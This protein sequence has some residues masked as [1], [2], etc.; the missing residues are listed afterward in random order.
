MEE[1]IIVKTNKSKNGYKTATII[2]SILVIF[3]IIANASLIFTYYKQGVQISYNGISYSNNQ[4]YINIYIENK[5][6]NQA[7]ISYNNFSIKSEN[8]NALTPNAMLYLDG[9]DI[10]Y[11]IPEY[12]IGSNSNI[13]IKLEYDKDKITNNASLYYNGK[14]IADL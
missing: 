14:K 8:S 9:N 5:S 2:L 11:Q 4:A 3:L 1:N 6:L 10:M 12:Y 7:I 13:K